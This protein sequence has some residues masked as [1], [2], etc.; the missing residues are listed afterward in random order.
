MD[1]TARL[2]LLELRDTTL[3]QLAHARIQHRDAL[4]GDRLDRAFAPMWARVVAQAEANLARINA[5]LGAIQ[6][7]A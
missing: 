5:D 1:A 6:K 4:A 2:H 3:M 7:A